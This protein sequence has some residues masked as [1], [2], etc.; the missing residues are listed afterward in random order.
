MTLSKNIEVQNDEGDFPR[1]QSLRTLTRH[2]SKNDIPFLKLT[3][4]TCATDQNIEHKLTLNINYND[5]KNN[6]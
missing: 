1:P 6:N 3:C 5:Y 2:L 4:T